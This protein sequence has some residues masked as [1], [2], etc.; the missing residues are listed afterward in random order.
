MADDS[1]DVSYP[2]IDP[3]TFD[4]IVVGTGLPES[5]IASAASGAGKSVLHL[6]PNSFYGSHFCSLTLDDFTSFLHSHLNNPSS[7]SMEDSTVNDGGDYVIAKLKPRRLYSDI[8]ISSHVSPES[9]GPSRKFNLDLAGPRVLLCADSAI[10]LILKSGA[11]H[12]LEFKSIDATFIY[13]LDGDGKFLTVPDSRAAIFKDRSLGLT[14]KNQLMRF[15]KL[16]QEHFGS[17]SADGDRKEERGRISEEDLESPFVVFLKKQRLPPKIKSIILYAI[18][19]ADYDQDGPDVSKNLLKTKDVVQSLALYHSSVGRFQNAMGAMIYPIYGQGELP[20]AFCRRAAVK[21][22]LYVMRMPV[23]SVLLDKENKHYKGVRLASGQDLFSH[24]LVMDPSFTVRLPALLSPSSNLQHEYALV[25]SLKGIDG[26]VARGVCI[27]RGSIKPDLSNL[28]VVFPPRSLFPEQVTSVRALQLG[29]NMAV[30]PSGLSVLY[31][32][33]LC[34]AA[35]Q[36]KELL[37]AAMNVLFPRFLSKNCEGSASVE[38]EGTA[39]ETKPTLMW[40]AI[41]I[42]ELETGSSEAINLCP[43]PDGKLDYSD[44]LE[45]TVKLF[46]KIYPQQELFPHTVTE[47]TEDDGDFPGDIPE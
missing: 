28:L 6:D 34:D 37:E 31:L 12:C 14:E 22:A 29:S 30:C 25:S 19:M 44:L 16:V 36:G 42:Q 40:N 32:S 18:A 7:S 11:S 3:S 41:Y 21:G 35:A 45:S 17:V 27:I 33:S 39:G 13:G 47:T 9:L 20:Q 10:D 2:S 24:E 4:L 5:V 23:T 46:E 1:A 38:T 26:K 15:F 43:M 8:E